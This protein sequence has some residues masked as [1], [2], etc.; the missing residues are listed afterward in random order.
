MVLAE[1]ALGVN[2]INLLRARRTGREPAIL[3]DHL[4]S[5]NRV[6]VSRSFGQNLLDLFAGEF[7]NADIGCRQFLQGGLLF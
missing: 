6:A 7:R 5:A 3:C 1:E 2:L 4:N